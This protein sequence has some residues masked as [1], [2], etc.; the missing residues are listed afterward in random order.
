MREEERE[1][2]LKEEREQEMGLI[3]KFFD[4]DTDG[5]DAPEEEEHTRRTRIWTRH[6]PF[7]P[8]QADAHR[9][10][11]AKMKSMRALEVLS[12]QFISCR[13]RK[14]PTNEECLCGGRVDGRVLLCNRCQAW[15]HPQ[16]IGV[17]ES[18]D[19]LARDPWY[20]DDCVVEIDE[21]EISPPEGN[22]VAVESLDKIS[23]DLRSSEASSST[24]S[25]MRAV[26]S[27][28]M[29]KLR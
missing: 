27:W 23:S 21:S 26:F 7:L 20:C 12:S 11:L 28:N 17:T 15:Y 10:L 5:E 16:C 29:C 9:A 24:L 3:E 14:K 4:W 25:E 13:Q 22:Q 2:I 18:I 6:G 19:E 1:E 8:G